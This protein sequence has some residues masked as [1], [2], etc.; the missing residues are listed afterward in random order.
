LG[1]AA[2]GQGGYKMSDEPL[3]ESALLSRQDEIIHAIIGG[4]KNEEIFDELAS[5][6]IAL[7]KLYIEQE[8]YVDARREAKFG[9]S[10]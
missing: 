10:L 9:C 1:Y 6:R 5:V 2:G 3:T 8:T 4:V 7:D